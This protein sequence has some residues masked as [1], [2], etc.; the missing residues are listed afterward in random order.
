MHTCLAVIMPNIGNMKTG[1]SDVTA[2]GR[3]SVTQKRPIT[4]TQ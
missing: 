1:N 2:N 3:I 4:M